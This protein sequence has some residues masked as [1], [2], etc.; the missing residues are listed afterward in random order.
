VDIYPA[1]DC[2]ADGGELLHD[3]G[4]ELESSSLSAA[5]SRG[6][7]A[8]LLFSRDQRETPSNDL[9]VVV[10]REVRDGGACHER[11]DLRAASPMIDVWPASHS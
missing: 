6:E 7:A 1:W 10:L 8:F 3:S 9:L 11:P 2:C 5:A 4:V